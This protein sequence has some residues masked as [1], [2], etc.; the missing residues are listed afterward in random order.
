MLSSQLAWVLITLVGNKTHTTHHN[1]PTS[2]TPTLSIGD[3]D[4]NT[5]YL[6][7]VIRN[8]GYATHEHERYS[9][10]SALYILE[11]VRENLLRIKRHHEEQEGK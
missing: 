4:T 2:N 6:N 1:M 8:L 3:W 11:T 10:N 9:F 5:Q 7:T